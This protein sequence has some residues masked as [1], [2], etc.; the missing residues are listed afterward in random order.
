MV[1]YST[2]GLGDLAMVM[3]LEGVIILTGGGHFELSTIKS[4]HSKHS[5]FKFKCETPWRIYK[6]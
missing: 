2:L 5:K 1:E 3:V 4:H 6:Y